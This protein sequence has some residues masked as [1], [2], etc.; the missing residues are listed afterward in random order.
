MNYQS[1]DQAP[2]L[3]LH[4]NENTAGCSP[5]VIAALHALT[6][7]EASYY[8][9]YA[10]I[11]AKCERYFDVA[12]NWVQVTNG[13]DEGLHLAAQAAARKL[14]RRRSRARAST[15]PSTRFGGGGRARSWASAQRARDRRGQP[16]SSR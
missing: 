1:P 12:P 8:P 2:G 5:A 6:R 7:E 9:D 13:L 14:A 10:P 15:A 16:T 11:T 3:R 4:F